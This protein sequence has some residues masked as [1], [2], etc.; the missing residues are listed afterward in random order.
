MSAHDTLARKLFTL[1]GR[2]ARSTFWV[3]AAGAGILFAALSNWLSAQVAPAAS[4][5][6]YLPLLARLLS[7]AV[8]RLHDRSRSGTLLLIIGIPVA[9]PLWLAYEIGFAAGTPGENPYG[10]DPLRFDNRFHAVPVPTPLPASQP[11]SSGTTS[12]EPDAQ[13]SSAA[14]RATWI[15][16]DV[17]QLNPVP[18]WAVHRPTCIDDVRDALKRTDG[19]VSVGGGHFSMG[20]QTASPGSLHLDMRSLNRVIAFSP[21]ER[22][23]RVQAGMRW[24]EL[25]EFLD[26]HG[27]AVQIMQSYANFTVGG[28]ISVNVHGRYVGLGPIAMSVR[29][30]T[31]VLPGGDV[32]EAR[33]DFNRELFY[34]VIGGLGALAVIVEAELGL[35]DNTRV[36]RSSATMPVERY[37]AWFQEHV[38]D[39]SEVIFHNADLY[40][41][42]CS[43]VR[44]VSWSQTRDA[45]TTPY[46]LQP[47]RRRYPL[48]RYALWAVS[49][50]PLGRWRR[51]HLLDPLLYLSTRVHWRNYEAG[52]DV[53]ELEPPSRRDT[54]YVLQEY[55][56]PVARFEAFSERL[57]EILTRHRVNIVNVSIR[58]AHADPGAL[59]AWARSETFA[60]VL[61]Y[62]QRTDRAACEAVGVWTRELI[63]AALAEGGT[64]Y[65]PYQLHATREQLMRAYPRVT[66]L[67]ALKRT[68]DPSYRLRST[69]WDKYYAPEHYVAPASAS[70]PGSATAQ[71]ALEHGRG[72]TFQAVY[73]DVT[74]RD[75]FYLFLQNVFHLYPEDR[76][77]HLILEACLRHEADEDIYRT[78]QQRLPDI[79]PRLAPLTHALPA[80]A[81][82]KAVM[83]AQTLQL[84]GSRRLLSGVLEIG[85]LGRY[86]SSLRKAIRVEGPIW[87]VDER[88]PGYGPTDIAERG[89]LAPL[90]TWIPLDD[91][92]PIPPAVPDA[93][94][95]LVTCYIG[96]HHVPPHKLAAFVASIARVLRP[97]GVFVL[98]DHDVDSPTMLAMATLAH[99]VFNVGTGATLEQDRDELRHF[100]SIETW[101]QRLRT[102]GLRDQG[103][104]LLQDHDPTRNVLLALVREDAAGTEAGS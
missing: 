43:T 94:L 22:T 85:G 7:L 46:R 37:H 34:G 103:E 21:I 48:E 16:N 8:R 24:C 57:S 1:R 95:D 5:L 13:P 88:E 59:L 11:D 25:Q 92:S 63:E 35:A 62:K 61:F 71:I 72:R 27:F 26:P 17:T 81:R 99:I 90:G 83:T 12:A 97:G 55:F 29:A 47:H 82:Q 36:K 33:P 84:L 91:Y 65:L 102:H 14:R 39:R 70:H 69:L 2:V 53:S 101:V 96:L 51:E 41:P 10:E 80:L 23:V 86:I 6:L 74:R 75:R 28:S 58:H 87:L 19:P 79:A 56:V 30:L 20:G 31:V 38:R 49:E 78:L 76:L 4:Y 93:S 67:F 32:V 45:V 64:Y 100:A 40:V 98:R 73:L 60:F 3:G 77:H 104:R 18:V 68:V 42:H 54:T 9:G 66:E 50:T 89:Q 52:P 15:V 44:A